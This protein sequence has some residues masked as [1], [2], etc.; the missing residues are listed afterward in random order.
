MAFLSTNAIAIVKG[1]GTTQTLF[2][3]TISIEGS[4]LS[5][6]SDNG[7]FAEGF[8]IY[9]N[10]NL[11]DTVQTTTVDM[12][13]TTAKVGDIITVKAYG[14]GFNDS[15]V[16]NSAEYTGGFGV[17]WATDGW[18]TIKNTSLAGKTAEIYGSQVGATREIALTNGNTMTIR[19]SNATDN[20]YSLS[21]GSRTTGLC[22]E[23]VDCFPDKYAMNSTDTSA[24]GWNGCQMRTIKMAQIFDLLPADLKAVIA[25]VNIKASRGSTVVTS[26]DKLFLL[27]EREIFATRQF[28]LQAEWNALKRWQ[29][30]ANNDTAAARVK[31]R[32]GSATSWWERSAMSGNSYSF[33]IVPASGSAS[34]GN[35]GFSG[36]VSPAFCI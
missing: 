3:P 16:S 5:I 6:T 29:Y 17:N 18:N 19:L 11:I 22:V 32:N 34:N 10:G 31:K 23:F 2:A 7:A 30:Y 15:T 12:G 33:C 36:G 26:Q 21:D 9:A 25:T 14:T 28:S 1:G 8:K 20:M 35:A 27:A 4:D 13:A 24:A